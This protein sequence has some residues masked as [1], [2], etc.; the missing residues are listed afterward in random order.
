K[1]KI[2]LAAVLLLPLGYPNNPSV[3][4]TEFAGMYAENA[5][6]SIF[7]A[8][9]E[10]R[11]PDGWWVRFEPG[12]N[13]ERARYQYDGP[14]FPTSTHDIRVLGHLG[15]SGRFGTG[16]HTRELIVSKVLEV[17]N[18]GGICATYP[19]K[20][21]DWKGAGP[22]HDRTRSAV[23][24]S[25]GSLVAI[26][27]WVGDISIWNTASGEMVK[28]FPS[29]NTFRPDDGVAL[30]LAFSPANDRLAVAGRDGFVR[31]WNP[32]DG[33][34]L[35][36]LRLP[37]AS[38]AFSPDGRTLLGG[39]GVRSYTWSM[40]NGNFLDSLAVPGRAVYGR[41]PPRIISS[42]HGVLHAYTLTGGLPI[43]TAAS[44]SNSELLAI[45]PNDQFLALKGDQD[46]VFLWSVPEGKISKR[47]GL[48]HF[49]WGAI[50]FSPDSKQIALS[51][52]GAFAIYIW[53][54]GT[55][56]PIQRIPGPALI[57]RDMWFTPDGDSIVAA[58]FQDTSL[59]VLPLKSA[60]RARRFLY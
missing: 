6:E 59:Y 23:S 15:P 36:R 38:V 56:D 10:D 50:A 53:D 35:W 14:G 48:P 20:P 18:P 58:A 37:A 25:D 33:R 2:Y 45:S 26:L 24:S 30:P 31:V 3:T 49:F 12:A 43:F 27:D 60:H 1:M 42:G 19:L 29:G 46:S 4:D 17:K 11:D 8:C 7:W 44:G 52:G 13:A 16:F 47:L 28:H 21:A 39:G 54:T 9:G 55:G 22:V 41:N 34:L 40:E 51:G 32:R 5:Q 57:T